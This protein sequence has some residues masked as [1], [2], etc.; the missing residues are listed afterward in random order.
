M[1]DALRAIDADDPV[2]TA[3]DAHVYELETAVREL[4]RRHGGS[5]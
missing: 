3:D 1:A 2:A 5:A 4:E